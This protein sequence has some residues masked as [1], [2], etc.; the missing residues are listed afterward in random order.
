MS[1]QDR[2]QGTGNREQNNAARIRAIQNPK[3]KIQNLNALHL[4]H[5]WSIEHPYAVIAFYLAAIGLAYM[6]VTQTL[7]RRFAPYVASPMVGVVTMMPD[8]PRRTWK[9]MSATRLSSRWFIFRA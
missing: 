2:E 8:F 9:R 1:R 6:T 7:P 3:S 4:I 5:K